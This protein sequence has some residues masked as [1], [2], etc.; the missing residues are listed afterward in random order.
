MVKTKQT[1]CGGSSHQP[2]GMTTATFTG[3]GRSKAD[4]EEQFIDAGEDTEKSIDFPKVLEDA[5]LPKEGEPGTS[6][7]KGKTGDPPAQTKEGA[8]APPEVNPPDPRPTDPKPDTSTDPTEASAEA[9]TKDPTQATQKPDEDPPPALTA[10]V[11]ACKAAGKTW[12]D[13]VVAQGEATYIT[14]FNT[15]QWL[16][17][18][19]KDKLDQANREQIFKCI[20]DKSGRFLKEDAFILY[21]A[22]EEEKQ[23]PRYQFTGDAKEALRDYYD[24]VHTLCEAQKNFAIIKQVLEEKIEDKSVFLDIIQQVQLPAVQV[25]VRTVEEEEKMEGKMYRELTLLHHL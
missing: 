25:Q 22:T 6:K 21:V 13:T 23:K 3:T 5:E 11:R 24:A 1:P 10:Y 15:L 14:L 2:S 9:P 4:R 16:G 7:S 20:K 12:L 19:H 17:L 8:E 18:K